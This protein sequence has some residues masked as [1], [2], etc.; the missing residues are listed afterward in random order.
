MEVLPDGLNDRVEDDDD[1]VDA[2]ADEEP[3]VNHLDVGGLGQLQGHTDE[4]GDQHKHTLVQKTKE[5]SSDMSFPS[6]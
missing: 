2:E 4:H 6:Y 1:K 3:E 5:G